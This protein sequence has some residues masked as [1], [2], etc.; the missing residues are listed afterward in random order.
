M[1]TDSTSTTT[2]QDHDHDHDHASI[3][4]PEPAFDDEDAADAPDYM[5]FVDDDDITRFLTTGCTV[6]TL[7]TGARDEDGA[8]VPTDVT[9]ANTG[10]PTQ[11]HS[12]QTSLTGR[13]SVGESI[14][15]AMVL[16]FPALL[17]FVTVLASPNILIRTS[18]LSIPIVTN[19]MV[20]VIVA[21]I[22]FVIS[23]WVAIAPTILDGL[24]VESD[25]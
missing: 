13:G 15:Y 9:I 20:A 23:L 21:W 5:V 4:S 17:S 11:R 2:E 1:T 8:P 16:A 10:G 12:L 24:G 25:D 18:G 6:G 7:Y 3:D 14:A 19:W 22:V